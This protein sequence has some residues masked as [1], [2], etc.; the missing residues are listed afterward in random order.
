MSIEPGYVVCP[1]CN[2]STEC[3]C[4]TCGCSGDEP[5]PNSVRVK[6]VCVVCKGLGQIPKL[7]RLS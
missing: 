2:A 7:P 5:Y 3:D 6:G 1:H 4:A